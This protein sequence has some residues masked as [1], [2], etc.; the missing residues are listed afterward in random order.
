[1]VRIDDFLDDVFLGTFM[2]TDRNVR[3]HI[4]RSVFDVIGVVVCAN[5]WNYVSEAIMEDLPCDS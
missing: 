3:D 2:D 1:M 5:A 4:L